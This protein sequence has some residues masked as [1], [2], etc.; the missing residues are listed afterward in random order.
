LIVRAT[1]TTAMSAMINAIW[2][3]MKTFSGKGVGG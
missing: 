1:K 2:V 3:P